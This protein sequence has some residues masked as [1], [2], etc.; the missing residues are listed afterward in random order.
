MR[1]FHKMREQKLLSFGLLLLTL[2]IGIVIGTLVN[3]GAHA[4]RGQVAA[5]DASPLHVPDAVQIGNEFTRLAKRLEPAVVNI[6]ADYTPKEA[7]N[8][9]DPNGDEG[10]DAL[11]QPGQKA[12]PISEQ[13]IAQGCP[14]TPGMGQ[15]RA[16][17]AV[18][19]ATSE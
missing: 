18:G 9:N 15:R 19:S 8:K 3:T 2:S 1:L 7:T 4:A 5:P 14:R 16:C 17:S 10:D 6:T 13:P 12:S 11:E